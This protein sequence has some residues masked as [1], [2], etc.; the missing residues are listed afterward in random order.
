[1]FSNR[2][3]IKVVAI[4]LLMVWPGVI[5]GQSQVTV[6]LKNLSRVAG[7]RQNQLKGFGIVTGLAGSGDG[8]I[9]FVNR[10]IANSL[11]RLGIKV[12]NPADAQLDNIAAVMVTA[13]LPPFKKS[14]DKINV[15][16]SSI[17]SADDLS[18]GVLMQ[19]PLK[20]GNGE[21]Y[22]V[23]QGPISKGGSGDDRH[24]TTLTMPEGAL[25]EREVPFEFVGDDASVG[26]QLHKS[27]FTTA[28][29]VARTIN[30]R[31]EARL[32]QAKNASTIKVQ[33][34]S[35]QENNVVRFISTIQNLQVKP[36]SKSKIIINERT[37]TVVMGEN[38]AVRPV[39][40][41]HGEISLQVEGEEQPAGSGE[42][43]MLSEATTVRQ[44]VDSLN[45]VGASTDAVIAIL[46][47]L[48]QADALN[49]P[50]ELM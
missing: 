46:E 5:F 12:E 24:L 7:V 45:A 2:L 31:F 11:Q 38:I 25:V 1:M 17:G 9:N 49:A 15:T 41:S 6:P 33:I 19:T 43:V 37:G 30:S 21:V 34:P 10:S 14:G 48:H 18:G 8:G 39:A 35:E 36:G 22:A 3:F 27:N 29:R 26:F 50:L 40:I 4:F 20:A 13:T 47:A 44:V 32:A 42:T 23:A 16:V 28:S